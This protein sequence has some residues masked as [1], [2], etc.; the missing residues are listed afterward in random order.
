MLLVLN[1]DRCHSVLFP[2]LEEQIKEGALPVRRNT[3]DEEMK[4]FNFSFVIDKFL[5]GLEF[6]M[7]RSLFKYT[8]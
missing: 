2:E 6:K 3:K 7:F 8:F 1:D 5:E 4:C